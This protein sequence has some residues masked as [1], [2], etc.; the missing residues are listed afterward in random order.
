MKTLMKTLAP[1]PSTYPEPG[2]GLRGGIYS[3]IGAR[4]TFGAHENSALMKTL[5]PTL[6]KTLAPTLGTRC[7]AW[8]S[9]SDRP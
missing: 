3:S 5:A 2:H 7:T 6:M 1:T 9:E 8:R 4:M